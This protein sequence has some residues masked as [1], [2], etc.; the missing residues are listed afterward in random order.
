MTLDRVP[1][2]STPSLPG[3]S[4]QKFFGN[5]T[6]SGYPPGQPHLNRALADGPDA[7][8]G[9]GEPSVRA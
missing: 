8:N 9:L 6:S 1:Q 7:N 4:T 3:R 2:S 5:S